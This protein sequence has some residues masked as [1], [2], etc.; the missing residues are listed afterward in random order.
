MVLDWPRVKSATA[1]HDAPIYKVKEIYMDDKVIFPFIELIGQ[2]SQPRHFVP[3]EDSGSLQD[4]SGVSPQDLGGD[5]TAAPDAGGD[6][7]ETPSDETEPKQ[8]ATPAETE[9]IKS[10]DVWVL[11]P[12]SISRIHN[13]PRT[14]MFSPLECQ[15]PPPIPLTQIDVERTT[16]TDADELKLRK[17]TTFGTVPT[18]TAEI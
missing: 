11:K 9:E 15:D 2:I 16:T 6:T 18:T 12:Y 13:D 8:G 5:F 4:D 17:S 7:A 14:S 10:K 3:T 1:L